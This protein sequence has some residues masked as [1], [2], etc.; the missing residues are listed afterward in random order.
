MSEKVEAHRHFLPA[1][2]RDLFLPLYDPLNRLLGTDRARQVLIHHSRLQ[3]GQKVLD[4]GCG[5]G[6]LLLQIRRAFPS[7]E[8]VGLDPDPK[9][10]DR[11]QRKADREGATVRLDEGFADALPYPDGSF[12][13]VFSSLMYH[14]LE[15]EDRDKMLR[16]ARRVL[17]G[18]GEFLLMDVAAPD[19]TNGFLGHLLR[20]H[21]RLKDNS[22]SRILEA[23]RGAGM[24][25]P[26]KVGD[27]KLL[28]ARVAYY[29]AGH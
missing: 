23:M 27:R 28:F 24:R 1:A 17:A 13:R 22:E 12:D 8:L 11:A 21:A 2:G 6:T 5:T 9:A 10:L 14:H 26:V 7:T 3:P 19:A 16:E 25:D 18:E 4:V 15:P 29:R 20:H